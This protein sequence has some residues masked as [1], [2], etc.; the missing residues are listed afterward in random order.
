LIDAFLEILFDSNAVLF[1]GSPEKILAGKPA[2]S[3]LSHFLPT[4]RI[5]RNWKGVY[6]FEKNWSG[7]EDFNL[8]PPGPEPDSRVYWNL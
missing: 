5:F 7:R 4:A 8:R 2:R 1:I 6:L 3:T